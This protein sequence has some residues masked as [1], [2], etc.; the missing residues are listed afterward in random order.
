ML[1]CDPGG[2]NRLVT[3][4][5]RS[6]EWPLT[7]IGNAWSRKYYDGP[8]H[9]F[10][11]PPDRPAI[12]LVFVQSRNGNTGGNNPSHLGAGIT[13]KC[14]LYEGLSRVA[15]DAVLA[16]ASTVGDQA[17]FT[18]TQPELVALRLE[19]G[20]PRHPTQMVISNAGHLNPAGRLFSMP[21][22]PV[23]LVAGPECERTLA[24]QL[25]DRSWITIVPIIT[26]AAS[27]PSAG[28]SRRRAW[29]MPAWC[30]TSISR[31]RRSTLVSRRRRGMWGSARCGWKRS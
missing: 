20:F 17:L 30:R 11:A 28:A 13:D 1:S 22:V 25:A 7:G 18:I 10:A 29:S 16:G 26:L 19:L 14:L 3:I 2:V 8:F 6:R 23:I 4:E 5:D 24:P 15:A 21:D 9:V 31:R 12:S 27:P